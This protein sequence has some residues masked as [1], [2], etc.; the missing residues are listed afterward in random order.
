MKNTIPGLDSSALILS[1]HQASEAL[2]QLGGKAR[3][4]ALLSQANLPIPEWFVVTTAAFEAC[5][6]EA[7]VWGQGDRSKVPAQVNWPVA[8]RAEL[9]GALGH[10][11]PNGELV[12]VRS[13][14]LD[15]DGLAHSFAGQLESFL[16]VELEDVPEKI[17][18]VWRSGFSDRLLAYRLEHGLSE[19]PQP[20]AV[21][22]QRMVQAECAGV[23]FS[24]DPVTGRRGVALVSA[25]RGLGDAL[26]S[27]EA[28][29]ETWQVSRDG[30]ILSH[31]ALVDE[32]VLTAEQAQAI[33]ALARHTAQHFG[34][35]Q[36]VEWAI[37][38]SGQLWLL[39]SRPITTLAQMA[40][41]DGPLQIWDN[42]NI[43]ESYGGITTPL[44]FSFARRA[45]EA[46]YR[47]FC[48]LMRVPEG[49]IA[50]HDTTFRCMLGLVRG[51]IYYNLLNWY[52]VLAL[53]P[54]FRVNRRFMEQMMGVR[55]ELPAD[56]LR[57]LESSTFRDKVQ[58]SI[59]LLNT[60]MGLVS[61]YRTLPRQIQQFYH[62][63]NDALELPPNT[64]A[65]WRLDELIAYYQTLEQK[66]LTRWDAP[67]VNDFFAMIFYGVLRKLTV[68]WCGDTAG[69]L[70]ND[71]VSGEGGMISAEPAQRVRQMADLAALHPNFVETLLCGSQ[72]QIE[73]A[74]TTLPGFQSAYKEYLEKFG[75][76]CLEELKLESPTLHDDPLMLLRSIGHLARHTSHS[77]APLRPRPPVSLREQAEILVHQHLRSRPLR[78]RLFNWVLRNARDRVRDR[79]NLRFER[80]RVFGRVR[81]IFVEIGQRLFALDVL[82]HPRD[83]FYLNLEEILGYNDGT[84]TCTDL[85]GMVALRKAEFDR[86]HQM[87][88]AGD[89]FTTYGPVHPLPL[90][91]FTQPTSQPA[92]SSLTY[93]GL[94]CCPGI[95]RAPVQ[96]ITDPKNAVLQPGRIL[97]AERTDPGWIL[98]FPGAA[99]LLV[100]RGSLLSH[101]AIVSREMGI[102]AIVS[103]PGLIQWL[104]DGDWVEMDGSTGHIKRI[105]EPA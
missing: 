37:D 82:D 25:V 79:E 31:Q 33:A 23:A 13:S 105:D 51:R 17:V 83:I 62:R 84:A 42:S 61:N 44:T 90:T 35:P 66:L 96:V 46:V 88:S 7:Q 60:L 92:T 32:R 21:L 78:R 49:A 95:V 50:R 24:A 47:E 102:P 80:T 8:I 10:L 65:Q 67:L 91:P 87:P 86:Y 57:S 12:A 28:D 6:T 20:P 77:S 18:E 93:Q 16:N 14:A 34:R 72:F 48:R 26:V 75:D 63:L 40:D 104:K 53:L 43:A 19:V 68:A 73:Q 101:S 30:E 58:D 55:E 1:S 29:A 94:G 81:R 76:R 97:V 22:V 5:L 56:V 100:E 3:S 2:S 11:C 15:E 9:V 98:L 85:K 54:G 74:M 52:R 59:R 71:L 103:I 45:Y 36:D 70:Q 4:L 99:G 89:R 64:L 41:P 39:Q 69:T 38:G 27:G